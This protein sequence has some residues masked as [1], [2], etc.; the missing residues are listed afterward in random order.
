MAATI[1]TIPAL[2]TEGDLADELHSFV[3][4]LRAQNVSPNTIYAYAGAVVSLGQYLTA[5]ELPTNVRDIKREHIE[6][7]QESLLATYKPATA[8]QRYRGAQRFFTG[9]KRSTTCRT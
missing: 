2:V 4:H 3:R 6:R 9:T 5:N 8:Q 1:P 7:W